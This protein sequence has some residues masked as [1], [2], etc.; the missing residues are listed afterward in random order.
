MTAKHTLS[1]PSPQ[2][3][4]DRLTVTDLGLADEHTQL[5]IQVAARAE[6]VLAVAA[7]GRWPAW[8][9]QA[10]LGYL[11]AEVLRQAADEEQL[12]FPGRGAPAGLARLAGD[13]AQLRARIEA[14][15]YAARGA[16]VELQSAGDLFP[17]WQRIDELSAGRYRFA[18]L[19]DG[20]KRW[21]LQVTRR[22]SVSTAPEPAS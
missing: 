9:L 19:E 17:V 3:A 20:P 22:E 11:S 4:D 7:E 6:T 5:L 16:Q 21:R 10:L 12:L 13:H 18:Y 8:E 1:D 14:L 2:A 15:E